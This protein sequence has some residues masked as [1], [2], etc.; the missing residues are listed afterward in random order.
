MMSDGHKSGSNPSKFAKFQNYPPRAQVNPIGKD[1]K[2]DPAQRQSTYFPQ[3]RPSQDT[4]R[5]Q[6]FTPKATSQLLLSKRRNSSRTNG[7]TVEAAKSLSFSTASPPNHVVL[8]NATTPIHHLSGATIQPVQHPVSVL[9]QSANLLPATSSSF[10]PLRGPVPPA[11]PP[12]AQQFAPHCGLAN[13]GNTCYLNSTLQCLRHTPHFIA[14]LQRAS[15]EMLPEGIAKPNDAS[16]LVRQLDQLFIAMDRKEQDT[17]AA[18]AP[19]GQVPLCLPSLCAV[20]PQVFKDT[21]SASNVMFEGYRQHDCQECLR[22]LIS[23]LNESQ[24]S[25]L[26]PAPAQAL[27]L[28][29]RP[30]RVIRNPGPAVPLPA[31]PGTRGSP[32]DMD[33]D[34]GIGDDDAASE[35]SKELRSFKSQPGSKRGYHLA[36]M[37]GTTNSPISSDLGGESPDNGSTQA[38]RS[39][40]ARLD[41][42]NLQNDELRSQAASPEPHNPFIH[43]DTTPVGMDTEE[44]VA[45]PQ[46]PSRDASSPESGPITVVS[47]HAAERG[48][49]PSLTYVDALFQGQLLYTTRC[50]RCEAE[51][52][53]S[54]GFHDLSLPVPDRPACLPAC[55]DDAYKGVEVLDG[56]NKFF[57]S[58]CH[59]HNE[60]TRS[61]RLDHLP[62]VLTIH[63]NR[64][65]N[66]GMGKISTHIQIPTTLDMSTWAL[67]CSAAHTRYRLHA[68]IFHSGQSAISGHYFA[69]IR[70]LPSGNV[71]PTTAECLKTASETQSTPATTAKTT[72]LKGGRT[73]MSHKPASIPISDD[74][75]SEPPERQT[76]GHDDDDDLQI[77]DVKAPP[78]MR[79]QAASRIKP[80]PMSSKPKPKAPSSTAAPLPPLPHEQTWLR[81]D[82]SRVEYKSQAELD[83]LIGCD[84]TSLATAYILFYHRV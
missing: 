57:C 25:I 76:Q 64:S 62:P 38:L 39:T 40:S 75:D 71:E 30:I 69:F 19:P 28:P 77:H 5:N 49:L 3:P 16:N 7:K 9:S 60:A 29:K 46:Q 11:P 44:E 79:T 34:D 13:L 61:V 15:S 56:N 42:V 66:L 45:T 36:H 53:R 21:L 17:F 14:C 72:G 20:R 43:R 73:S 58:Q 52:T 4:E 82:D 67:A 74:E 81:F 10:A 27:E 70:R 48:Q 65:S 32:T 59:T 31:A 41:E 37:V 47:H 78:L 50:L 26:K 84:S 54:E 68:V 1:A 23:H 6:F 51:T 18:L 12:L 22:Y 80:T 33:Q 55:L 24:Q 35:T 83:K 2:S 8:T 63:L